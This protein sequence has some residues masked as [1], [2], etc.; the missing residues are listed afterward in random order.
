MPSPSARSGDEGSSDRGAAMVGEAVVLG[1]V[2]LGLL[3][4]LFKLGWDG[5]RDAVV[6]RCGGAP[7]RGASRS[8]EDRT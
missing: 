2:V 1:L 8:D 4:I 3:A 5:W 7:R 6:R